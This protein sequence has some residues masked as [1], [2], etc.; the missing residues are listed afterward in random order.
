MKLKRARVVLW[1]FAVVLFFTAMM[2]WGTGLTDPGFDHVTW[3]ETLRAGTI[4]MAGWWGI[5][6]Y[7]LV[8]AHIFGTEY[9]DGTAA[10]MLTIP[11]RREHIVAAKLIVLAGWVVA[12]A[13]FS[14]LTDVCSALVLGAE[15]FA[16]S[17]MWTHLGESLLATLLLYMTLPLIAWISMLGRGYMAPMLFASGATAGSMAC[18]FLGWTEWFPWAMASTIAGG[19]G[20]PGIAQGDLGA[21]S[22]A[23]AVGLFLAGLVAVVWY[24]RRADTPT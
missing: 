12:L 9:S 1:S 2:T 21:G 11:V 24:V 4:F 15:G 3:D 8:A 13:L 17:L 7:S 6:V 14:V 20:P 23:I 5:L 10:S 18:G 19:M 16:W 22:W